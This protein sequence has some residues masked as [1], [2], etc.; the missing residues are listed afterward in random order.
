D[1][2]ETLEHI[3]I[4]PALEADWKRIEALTGKT[5]W[6]SLTSDT[7][8]K[9]NSQTITKVI[10]NSRAEDISITRLNL[11]KGLIKQSV[12][13]NLN[14]LLSS[15]KDARNTVLEILQ[16]FW[17]HFYDKIFEKEKRKGIMKQFKWSAHHGSSSTSM[18]KKQPH[19]IDIGPRDG[20]G[21]GS[22]KVF[23]NTGVQQ[24]SRNEDSIPV[25]KQATI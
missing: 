17:N 6:N 9:V 21:L 16:R 2:I 12:V 15:H 18:K 1:E 19:K 7:K 4:C 3:T 8:Y 25:L 11:T 23:I 20:S 24:G 5:A 10:F 14:E 22:S 13:N